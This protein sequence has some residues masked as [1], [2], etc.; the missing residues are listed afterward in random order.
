MGFTNQNVGFS[1][2]KMEKRTENRSEFV[3]RELTKGA[4]SPASQ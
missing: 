3:N 1:T 2:G 4:L